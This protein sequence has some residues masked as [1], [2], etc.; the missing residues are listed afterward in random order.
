MTDQYLPST[1]S[2]GV[3]SRFRFF[4]PPPAGAFAAGS[5]GVGALAT[6]G[7]SLRVAAGTGVVEERKPEPTRA[8]SVGALSVPVSNAR[9]ENDVFE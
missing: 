2:S 5:C 4:F 6:F 7:V 9:D 3:H 8:V 1:P